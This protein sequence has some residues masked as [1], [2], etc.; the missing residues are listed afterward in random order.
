MSYKYHLTKTLKDPEVLNHLYAYSLSQIRE[1]SSESLFNEYVNTYKH[2]LSKSGD[3]KIIGLDAF[4]YVYFTSGVCGAI[5]AVIFNSR[6]RTFSTISDDFPYYKFAVK[7]GRKQW[8]NSS[9]S[10]NNGTLL[11]VS[12]PQYS[13]GIFEE[14]LLGSFKTKS[15]MNIFYDMSYVGCCLWK[16]DIIVPNTCKFCAFS[17]SKA[18]GLENYRLGILFS[19]YKLSSLDILH[20]LNYLNHNS[21]CLSI[22]MMKKFN[23][24]YVPNKYKEKYKLI[25]RKHSLSETHCP[26]IALLNGQRIDVS[27]LLF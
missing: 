22:Y 1:R 11:F 24:S 18:F 12:N 6:Y 10:A 3:I 25:C 17:L 21:L 9:F 16:G 13:N 5:E 2:W 15:D 14:N 4:P 23:I 7:A 19:K 8:K 26:W 20:K 27:H